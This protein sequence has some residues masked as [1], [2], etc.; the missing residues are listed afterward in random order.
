MHGEL[1]ELVALAAYG[2]VYLADN[3]PAPPELFPTAS[4]FKYTNDVEFHR[5]ARRFGV[6]PT[7]IV[8]GSSCAA[9]YSDLRNRG[10]VSLRLARVDSAA[11]TGEFPALPAHVATAFANGVPAALVAHFG[12]QSRESWTGNWAVTIPKH[13]E[14]R[15]WS[16]RFHGSPTDITLREGP[17]L[18]AAT[19][20]LDGALAEVS[21]FAA[22][23]SLLED[24]NKV[25]LTAR[26]LLSSNA[27]EIPYHPDMLPPNGYSLTARRLVAAA[28][29]AWVF[30][31]MGSW[32]DIAVGDPVRYQVVS[33][34]LFEAVFDAVLAGTNS[35]GVATKTARSP[36]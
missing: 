16:A 20:R 17:S 1:A 23:H 27:P 31:G 18:N 32:N 36:N 7:D 2:S 35:G 6:L 14:Q 3:A 28:S 25:F 21:A 10:A 22:G 12:E 30:G 15:I 9:W 13:P 33:A 4:V 29:A 24:W 11:R 19:Q 34:E 5:S 8:V 26:A